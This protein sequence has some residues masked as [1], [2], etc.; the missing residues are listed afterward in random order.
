MSTPARLLVLWCPDWS[1][2]AALADEHTDCDPQT[3]LALAAHGDIHSASVSA[4]TAGVR[5]GQRVRDAQVTCPTL[6]VVAH[7][8]ER[9]QRL[10]DQVLVSLSDTLARVSVV[11]PGMLCATAR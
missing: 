8:P 5:V 10:W 9:D 2:E 4:R 3:P 7:S 6:Q 1:I 11:E